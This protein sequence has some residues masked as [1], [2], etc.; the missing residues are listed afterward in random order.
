MGDRQEWSGD[1]SQH[2]SNRKTEKRIGAALLLFFIMA[3]FGYN[4]GSDLARR[5]NARDQ[6]AAAGD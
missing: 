1:V 3:F 4:I 5:D 2:D 6:A